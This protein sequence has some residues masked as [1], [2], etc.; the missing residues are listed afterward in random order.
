MLDWSAVAERLN[1]RLQATLLSPGPELVTLSEDRLLP[2]IKYILSSDSITTRRN[3]VSQEL[4][5]HLQRLI[6]LEK[7]RLRAGSV[8]SRVIL[9]Q[10]RSLPVASNLLKEHAELEAQLELAEK[11]ILLDQE[12]LH[13]ICFSCKTIVTKN[14]V[15]KIPFR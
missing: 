1:A 6:N 2:R 3:R 4:E 10:R 9:L 15:Y 11:A 7:L 5:I 12:V 8:A 13:A 14:E